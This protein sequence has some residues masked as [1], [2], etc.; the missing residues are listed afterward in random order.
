VEDRQALLELRER[1]QELPARQREVVFLH[2]SGWRY[3]ELAE[4]LGVSDTRIN[5]L[6]ARASARMREMDVREQDVR[7][8]RGRRLREIAE[9]PPAYIVASI[10]RTP[11]ADPKDGGHEFRR[12]WA[13]LVLAIEDYRTA[14][15]ITDRVLPLGSERHGAGREA[16]ARRM[17]GFRRERGLGLGFER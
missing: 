12:E 2:A 5:Q 17:A 11:R 16:L 6:L 10:G 9:D 15:G 3:S 14:N 7:S 8:P 1:L 4:R 13:R